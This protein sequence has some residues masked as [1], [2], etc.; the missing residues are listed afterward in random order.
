MYTRSSEHRRS[1]GDG[2]RSAGPLCAVA[3]ETLVGALAWIGLGS[4]LGSG[5]GFGVRVR[6]RVRVRDDEVEAL[7]GALTREV[8]RRVVMLVV[9]VASVLLGFVP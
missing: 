2:R 8:Q 5:L 3:V 4:G 1:A 7:V 9:G 6:V